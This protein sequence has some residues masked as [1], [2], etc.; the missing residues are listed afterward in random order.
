PV[1][2]LG[3]ILHRL[4]TELV[5]EGEP[6]GLLEPSDMQLYSIC[7]DALAKQSVV[8]PMQGDEMVI[9][10]PGDIDFPAQAFV[11]L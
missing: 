1:D 6:L 11:S 4:G 7:A 10:H 9:D 5:P 8:P 2:A 3:N